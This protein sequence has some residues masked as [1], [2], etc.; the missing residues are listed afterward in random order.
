[1]RFRTW[2]AERRTISQITFGVM[3]FPDTLPTLLMARKTQP[4]LIPLTSSHSSTAPFTQL[5]IGTVLICPA[6]PTRSAITQ[7]SSRSWMDSQSNPS[8]S[9]RL[10]PQPTSSA[11]I[12]KSRFPR[13]VFTCA[14]CRSR[15]PSSA[16]SQLPI[17]TPIQRTPLTR[18]MPAAASGLKKPES[19]ASYATRRT[20]A[21]RGLIV[22]AA[23]CFCSRKIRYRRTTVRLNASRGSE[24]YQSTNSLIA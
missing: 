18:L 14:A 15:L 7:C 11:N 13:R 21:S 12:A 8:S 24:Q 9:P 23:S 10:K 4:S 19:A 20:A 2:R 1:L 6:L 5:G 22:V 16:L 17:R 3:P